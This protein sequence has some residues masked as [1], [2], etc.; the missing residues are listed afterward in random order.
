MLDWS[1]PGGHDH[2]FKA[3]ADLSAGDEFSGERMKELNERFDTV[4]R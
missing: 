4:F 2:Y 3:I 1:L